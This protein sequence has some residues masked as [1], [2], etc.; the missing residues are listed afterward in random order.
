M[1]LGDFKGLSGSTG[2]LRD[3]CP[4][5]G[6]S[7][8]VRKKYRDPPTPPSNGG[9]RGGAASPNFFPC[10]AQRLARDDEGFDPGGGDGGS[11]DSNRNKGKGMMIIPLD[12]CGFSALA[13]V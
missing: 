11:M 5:S 12:P 6:K 1:N 2:G 8:A 10:A 3:G 13:L 4:F 9:A 7:A